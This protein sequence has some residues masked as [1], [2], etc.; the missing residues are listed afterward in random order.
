MEV[1]ARSAAGIL[2]TRALTRRGA[3]VVPGPV[4][5][6]QLSTMDG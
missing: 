4:W 3:F 2:K 1:P 5:R 6:D